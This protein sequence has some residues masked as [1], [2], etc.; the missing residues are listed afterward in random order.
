MLCCVCAVCRLCPSWHALAY[1]TSRKIVAGAGAN[2]PATFSKTPNPCQIPPSPMSCQVAPHPRPRL[3]SLESQK[4]REKR[5][6]A[7]SEPTEA[8]QREKKQKK[9]PRACSRIAPDNPLA[10]RLDQRPHGTRVD[11]PLATPALV[12]LHEPALPLPVLL[13]LP[14]DIGLL[15]L[16]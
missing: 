6:G 7:K 12:P 14:L 1:A 3:S 4:Q 9:T 11:L 16:E 2:E 15:R 5:G 8:A 10:R 13:P